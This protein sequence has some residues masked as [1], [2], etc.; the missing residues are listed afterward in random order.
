[1]MPALQE[2]PGRPITRIAGGWIADL[3]AL[4]QTVMLCPF[5]THKFNPRKH[6]YELWR[7]DWLALARCDAC[8]QTS[9]ATKVFIHQSLHDA[10][11]DDRSR[12]R[13]RWVS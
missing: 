1:M 3:T 9:R 5:C 7:E 8:R 2:A 10:V 12:H 6:H 13:G 4:K 11:G